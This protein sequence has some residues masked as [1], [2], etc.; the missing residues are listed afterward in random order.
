MKNQ[1]RNEYLNKRNELSGEY[2]RENK[3]SFMATFSTVKWRHLFI[4]NKNHF[5]IFITLG[6]YLAREK[7][8]RYSFISWTMYY[9]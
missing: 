1:L 3:Y 6:H 7:E 8:N 4:N 9:F 2:V 5:G